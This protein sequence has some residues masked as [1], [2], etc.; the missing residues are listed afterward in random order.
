MEDLKERL[1]DRF[2]A[3]ELVEYLGLTTE[4]FIEAFWERI[5]DNEELLEEVGWSYE[6][7]DE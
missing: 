5:L 3:A 7:E 4:D 6:D 2:T 1:L